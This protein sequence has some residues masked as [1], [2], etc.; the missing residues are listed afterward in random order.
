M[1]TLQEMFVS[2]I[3]GDISIPET[4]AERWRDRIRHFAHTLRLPRLPSAYESW[5]DPLWEVLFFAIF[6]DDD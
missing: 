3:D 4:R 6:G 2:V 1:R 5:D